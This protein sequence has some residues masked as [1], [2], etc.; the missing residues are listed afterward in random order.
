MACLLSRASYCCLTLHLG[1]P[2]FV[3]VIRQSDCLVLPRWN[4]RR[5]GI[6]A[7]WAWPIVVRTPFGFGS[8]L[9]VPL[10]HPCQARVT[11]TCRKRR[12][13]QQSPKKCLLGE[14]SMR[15]QR[16]SKTSL[17]SSIH[18]QRFL[19]PLPFHRL[20]LVV[21]SDQI[22]IKIKANASCLS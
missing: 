12:P 6:F 20:V 17:S 8:Q 1:C 19:S 14:V 15:N 18:R 22:S 11:K 7:K 9:A 16:L 5:R 10:V 13:L 4:G 21:I 2:V 3:V